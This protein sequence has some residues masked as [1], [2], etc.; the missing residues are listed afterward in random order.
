MVLSDSALQE[1][2]GN[3][4]RENFGGIVGVEARLQWAEK[5]MGGEK[6]KT[7]NVDPF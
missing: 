6:K 3:H 5:W 7:A 1:V 4:G 2:T